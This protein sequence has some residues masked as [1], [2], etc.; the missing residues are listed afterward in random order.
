MR[1]RD[2]LAF[3][4]A[5]ALTVPGL[6]ARAEPL[7]TRVTVRVIARGGKFLGDDVGGAQITIRDAQS[8]EILSSGFT[9]GG[10]GPA[11]LMTR[12]LA[13]TQTIP[14]QDGANSAARYDADLALDRPRW[15]DVSATGPLVA[16]QP[17]RVSQTLWLFPGRNLTDEGTQDRS[18]LLEIPG[19]LVEVIAPPAHYLAHRSDPAKPFEIRANV[20]MMCGC[21]IGAPPWPASDFD[22]VAHVRH[23]TASVA[24][25]LRFDRT[26][27]DGAPS[28]FVSRSWIPGAYG[29]F[30]IDV[31]A[32]Q[33]ST[34]NLGVGRSSTTLFAPAK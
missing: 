21:P 2:A 26:E 24:V 34:G 13:R 22:V 18:L 6:P 33:K 31:V 20:T 32:A 30:T 9:H 11:S 16:P 17:A 27:R 4:A 28:Q 25:P 23:G 12:P 8:G 5:A 10:S 14:T 7:P 15:V 19:L 29:V 3:L 1:R